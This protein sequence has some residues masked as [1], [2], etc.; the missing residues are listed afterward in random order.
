[1]RALVAIRRVGITSR[2]AKYMTTKA[3][4]QANPPTLEQIE[5]KPKPSAWQHNLDAKKTLSRI[6]LKQSAQFREW[7]IANTVTEIRNSIIT[8]INERADWME[9]KLTKTYNAPICHELCAVWIANQLEKAGT[10][11]ITE[12]LAALA[13]TGDPADTRA[14]VARAVGI[15]QQNVSSRFPNLSEITEQIQEADEKHIKVEFDLYGYPFE[16]DRRPD[17]QKT[18]HDSNP[19][20]SSAED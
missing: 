11:A 8:Q 13:V 2:Y 5:V 15:S 9:E 7:L 16:Y 12:W 14:N 17:D 19:G 6:N 4:N 20:A 18:D 1:M 10:K 3:E